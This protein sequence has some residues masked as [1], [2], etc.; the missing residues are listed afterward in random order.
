MRYNYALILNVNPD[1]HPVTYSQ[2]DP[3]QSPLAAQELKESG[4][5][6]LQYRWMNIP[7]QK[8]GVNVL[9]VHTSK[10]AQALIQYWN[11]MVWGVWSYQL[12]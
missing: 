1:T 11:N 10:D 9:W 12:V 7:S 3:I 8:K 5:L 2:D 6:C 4:F